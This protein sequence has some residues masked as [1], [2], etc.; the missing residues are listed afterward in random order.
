MLTQAT[1]NKSVQQVAATGC[2]PSGLKTKIEAADYLAVSNVK[3]NF[4]TTGRNWNHDTNIDSNGIVQGRSVPDCSAVNA[5]NRL[6]SG[7]YI[8]AQI[9]YNQRLFLTTTTNPELKTG[10]LTISQTLEGEG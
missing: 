4:V 5:S 3:I 7:D 6:N 8:Y 10:A 2:V 1:V 9:I